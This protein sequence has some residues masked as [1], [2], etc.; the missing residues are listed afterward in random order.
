MTVAELYNLDTYAQETLGRPVNTEQCA[1]CGKSP[2]EGTAI[3]YGGLCPPCQAKTRP[4][5]EIV[6]LFRP[7]VRRMPSAEV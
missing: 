7:V 6:Q 1:I 2:Q 4:T 3:L 5:Q